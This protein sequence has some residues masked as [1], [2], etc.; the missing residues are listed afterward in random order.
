M[1]SAG[2]RGGPAQAAAGRRGG[3]VAAVPGRDEANEPRFTFI[4]I[5]FADCFAC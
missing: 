2:G 1:V 4:T 5:D 3:F